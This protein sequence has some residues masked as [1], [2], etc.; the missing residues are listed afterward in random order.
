LPEAIAQLGRQFVGNASAARLLVNLLGSD[1]L[2]GV[3]AGS[4]E[5]SGPRRAAANSA[6][7]A[8]TV[9]AIA[10]AL[11]INATDAAR[12][13]IGQMIGG[14]F[15][16]EVPSAGAA[17]LQAVSRRPCAETDALLLDVLMRMSQSP[18][19]EL[20]SPDYLGSL[21]AAL[22]PSGAESVRVEIAARMLG[23]S[24]SLEQRELLAPILL[25]LR[26]ENLAAQAMLYHDFN[27]PTAMKQTIEAH[28][29]S[30]SSEVLRRLLGT[31]L[32]A[33]R[34]PP[35][36]GSAS[37]PPLAADVLADPRLP[38]RVARHVWNESSVARLADQIYRLD[39]LDGQA[40][41]VLLASSIP[42]DLLRSRL[43]GALKRTWQE[44]PT[45]LTAAA[46]P[47]D[48]S[49]E[50]GFVVVLKTVA[51]RAPAGSGALLA[52]GSVDRLRDRQAAAKQWETVAADWKTL[53]RDVLVSFCERLEETSE[54]RAAQ[55]GP[56][57]R[58]AARVPGDF[59]VAIHDGARV[60][61]S[62]ALD[63]PRQAV[64]DG[65]SLPVSP[66]QVRH[67]RIEETNRLL[68]LMGHYRHRLESVRE[69]AAGDVVW[70][71]GLES[72]DEGQVRSVD[73][74]LRRGKGAPAAGADLDE[75]LTIDVL[76]ITIKDPAAGAP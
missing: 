19:G 40:N 23:S 33:E 54:A 2:G 51:R 17:A 9:A 20:L 12:Q 57:G 35:R 7:E 36:A 60:V 29:T 72:V 39:S 56:S 4:G 49:V 71:S 32:A 63:W 26:P 3:D 16:G 11:S 44:G 55:T 50:P 27:T 14:E 22:T 24:S 42:S 21:L 25:E 73:V 13:A 45:A 75:K 37:G 70:L 69:H 15:A 5:E 1:E 53:G 48:A 31:P 18:K 34:T 64:I 62:Y 61:S 68:K 10:E 43:L 52:S 58:S 59:P 66:T 38:T 8:A 76:A 67:V 28:L 46:L 65:Q 6:D 74:L 30:F 41:R 47:T